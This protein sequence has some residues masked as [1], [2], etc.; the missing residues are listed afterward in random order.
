MLKYI[1]D[2]IDYSGGLRD[3]EQGHDDTRA[4]HV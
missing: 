4:L 1:G 3:L 2:V